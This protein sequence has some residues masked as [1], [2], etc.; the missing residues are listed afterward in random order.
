[1]FIIVAELEFEKLADITEL[2]LRAQNDIEF[3]KC[4]S[5]LVRCLIRKW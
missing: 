5:D 1:M 4:K 2:V 3:I